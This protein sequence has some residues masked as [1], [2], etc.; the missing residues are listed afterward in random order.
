M[1][2]EKFTGAPAGSY[3]CLF[4]VIIH[5]LYSII[6]DREDASWHDTG[7]ERVDLKKDVGP[8][9]KSEATVPSRF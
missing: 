9:C 4:D 7:Y 8:S 5:R 2:P 1:K 3:I 6:S